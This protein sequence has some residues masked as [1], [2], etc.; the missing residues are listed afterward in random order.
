MQKMIMLVLCFMLLAASAM[1]AE[2][3]YQALKAEPQRM[4]AA[5]ATATPPTQ[6]D[7]LQLF[8]NAARIDGEAIYLFRVKDV[9][10]G[11]AYTLGKIYGLVSI[12][13]QF[14]SMLKGGSFVGASANVMISDLLLKLNQTPNAT[15]LNFN[16][17]IGFTGGYLSGMGKVKSG[18]DGGIVVNVL[19][20]DMAKVTGW[21]GL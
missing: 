17:S 16:P 4:G 12:D 10:I 21:I 9:G 6:A 20:I 2:P 8:P 11:P 14:A 18:F 19:N 15:L 5:M 1:A 3:N 7:I 13:A